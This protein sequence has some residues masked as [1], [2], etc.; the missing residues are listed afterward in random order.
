[1]LHYDSLTKIYYFGR[2]IRMHIGFFSVQNQ[3]CCMLYAFLGRQIKLSCVNFTCH[4]YLAFLCTLY[5][6]YLIIKSVCENNSNS[7]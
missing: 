4:L 7:L 2:G 5:I 6:Y 1:M 3:F